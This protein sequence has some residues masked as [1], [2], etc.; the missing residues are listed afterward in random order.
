MTT[1]NRFLSSVDRI[2]KMEISGETAV[3]K[4]KDFDVSEFFCT[5]FSMLNGKEQGYAAVPKRFNEQHH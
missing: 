4:P 1:G 3:S 5:G 2:D